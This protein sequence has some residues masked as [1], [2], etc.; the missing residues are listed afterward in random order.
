[1]KLLYYDDQYKLDKYILT[2]YSL[3]ENEKFLE[4]FPGNIRD[5]Q[6]ILTARIFLTNYRIIASGYY[7]EKSSGTSINPGL[8]RTVIQLK[9]MKRQRAITHAIQK[10][11]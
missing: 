11:L 7:V 6:K 10:S 1:M 2:K 9:K 3:L 4:E 8:I 5:S